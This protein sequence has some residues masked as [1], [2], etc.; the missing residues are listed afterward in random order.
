MAIEEFEA[1]SE[2]QANPST[3]STKSGVLARTGLGRRSST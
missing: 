1:N 2:R 3:G